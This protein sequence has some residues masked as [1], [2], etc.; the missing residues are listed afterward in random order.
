MN[1]LKI[2]LI[3]GIFFISKLLL[4][5]TTT[6]MGNKYLFSIFDGESFNSMFNFLVAQHEAKLKEDSTL[7]LSC[8]E[9]LDDSLN[10][11]IGIYKF[12]IAGSHQIQFLYLLCNDGKRKFVEDYS[13]NSVVKQMEQFF[14][15]NNRVLSEKSKIAYLKQISEFLNYRLLAEEN[16]GYFN[17]IKKE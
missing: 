15:K 17:E 16:R 9:L 14:N 4:S 1:K 11:K 6:S 13:T 8:R 12:G 2:F 7:I 10:L 3:I 5:Q